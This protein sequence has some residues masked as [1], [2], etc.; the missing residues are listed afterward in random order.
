MVLIYHERG[1]HRDG[2]LAGASVDVFL[3]QGLLSKALLKDAGKLPAKENPYKKAMERV[4]KGRAPALERREAW[5]Q[6]RKRALSGNPELLQSVLASDKESYWWKAEVSAHEVFYMPGHPAN[7][8]EHVFLLYAERPAADK[9]WVAIEVPETTQLHDAS[10]RD[11]SDPDE[12]ITTA[13]TIEQFRKERALGRS[14]H[15][16]RSI[17]N[18]TLVRDRVPAEQIVAYAKVEKELPF[19]KSISAE[20]L[21]LVQ[22]FVSS[23]L[24]FATQFDDPKD[25]VLVCKNTDRY[26]IR[27]SFNKAKVTGRQDEVSSFFK[28]FECMEQLVKAAKIIDPAQEVKE[29]IGRHTVTLAGKSPCGDSLERAVTPCGTKSE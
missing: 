26:Q 22:K 19:E 18:E 28:P 5:R 20:E 16:W 13:V 29:V 25:N 24:A 6:G 4:L 27:V 17:Y 8:E 21:G 9:D 2:A 23:K 10:C 15:G 1:H 14:P 3:E 7:R 12:W 11:R